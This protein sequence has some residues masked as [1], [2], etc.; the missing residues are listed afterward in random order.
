M[1][2]LNGVSGAE[3]EGLGADV[4]FTSSTQLMRLTSTDWPISRAESTIA[5]RH[6]RR[7]NKCRGDHANRPQTNTQAGPDERRHGMGSRRLS[8]L[9]RITHSY[10]WSLA[11]PAGRHGAAWRGMARH[12]MASHGMA[13][14]KLQHS[15][16]RRARASVNAAHERESG[17]AHCAQT[18]RCTA[19]GFICFIRDSLFC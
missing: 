2:R 15:R 10:R 8:R 17:C 13:P 19:L 5:P 7:T 16:R 14:T 3:V 11:R 6:C 4:A 12:R 18:G 9:L 1:H